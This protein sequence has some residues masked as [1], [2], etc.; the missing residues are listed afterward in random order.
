MAHEELQAIPKSKIEEVRRLAGLS[1]L[2]VL[3]KPKPPKP[4]T[5]NQVCEAFFAKYGRS[6]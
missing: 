2:N 6:R 3:L 5:W 4:P 1:E